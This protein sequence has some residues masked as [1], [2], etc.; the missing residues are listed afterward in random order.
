[1]RDGEMG[2]WSGVLV[3]A[4]VPKLRLGNQGKSEG[5]LRSA[6]SARSEDLAAR[7]DRR[8]RRTGRPAVTGFGEVERTSLRN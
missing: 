2:R 6:V 1:M 8:S 3:G 5:D 4:L 7:A